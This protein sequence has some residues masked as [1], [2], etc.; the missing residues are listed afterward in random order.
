MKSNTEEE[1]KFTAIYTNILRRT[2]ARITRTY[3]VVTHINAHEAEGCIDWSDWGEG[4]GY[5]NDFLPEL[6]QTT[7][8]LH[9]PINP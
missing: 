4:D 9:A 3:V 1:K 6:S 7:C 8:Y 2:I 5:G